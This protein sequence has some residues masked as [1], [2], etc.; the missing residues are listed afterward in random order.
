MSASILYRLA[1]HAGKELY[2]RSRVV[3]SLKSVPQ[4]FFER[5][6]EASEKGYSLKL[7]REMSQ[8]EAG[9]TP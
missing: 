3:G 9:F 5:A 1:E 6:G 7:L 2:H 8:T 4:N